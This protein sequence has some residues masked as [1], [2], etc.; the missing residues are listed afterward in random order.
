MVEGLNQTFG[1]KCRS[2]ANGASDAIYKRRA[3]A[4]GALTQI[5]LLT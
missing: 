1:H 5:A 3:D 4:N 2:D